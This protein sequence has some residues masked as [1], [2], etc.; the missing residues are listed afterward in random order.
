MTNSAAVEAGWLA[1]FLNILKLE[2]AK[3][4]DDSAVVGG[5]DRFIERWSRDISSQTS[6]V[7]LVR[8]L[9]RPSY[10]GMSPEQRAKWTQE[11]RKL[12][13]VDGAASAPGQETPRSKATSGK[14][15]S[16]TPAARSAGIIES[17]SETKKPQR[18]GTPGALTVDEPVDRLRGVDTKLS[19]RLK[20][21]DVATVRDLLY[22][23][24]RRHLDYSQAT[25]ITDLEPGVECTVV[26]SIW[27]S[28]EI[29]R[30]P[31]GQRKDTEALL[32]DDTGNIRVVWFG[33]RY[34][35]RTL[36][37]NL[38][39]AV[40]GK[41]SVFNGHLVFQSPEY[42]LLDTA[43]TQA[44]SGSLIHTGRMVPVYPLTEGLTGRNLRRIAWQALQEWLEGV[45]EVLPEDLLARTELIPLRR[46]IAQAHYPD[47]AEAW[48]LARQRLAF[49]ELVTLQ[50]AVLSRKRQQSQD[51]RGIK[52]QPEPQTLKGF[53]GSLPFDLTE[54]QKRCLEEIKQ[55]LERGTP[56]MN[57]LLQGEVGSGKTVVALAA[58]LMVAAAGHQAAIMV[59]TEIL[60]EQ[61]FQTVARL[62]SGL[63]SPV[64]E[65][66]QV[67]VYPESLSRPVSVGLITG[68]TKAARKRELTKM[69]S[70]GSLDILIGTQALI[71]QG[72]AM[73]R[74]ALAVAD[75]QHRFGV[76]QRSALR[77]KGEETPHTLIMSATP[78]PRT[79]SLTLYGDLEISCLDQLP[80]G[81]QE[82]WTRW[83]PPE[84]R[85][86]AHGFVRK[87]I[88]EGR[89][90][91]VICPLVE[92]S[93]SM[94]TK[95][96]TAE[97]SRLSQEVF[98]DLRLG[99]LHG[100]MTP[101]T[102]DQVMRDFRDGELDILVSTPVVEVGIDV[103]NATVMMIEG[104]DRFGL[105]QLHQFRGR[106]GRGEHKSYCLLLSDSP[107][108][109]AQERLSALERIHDGFK[110]AEADL[111]LRGP[112]DFF[113]T[114]QSGLPNLRM[115]QL[116]DR[117]LLEMARVEA[118]RII[119]SD[120][121]LSAAEHSP[122]ARQV[123]RFLEWVTDEA[124]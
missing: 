5:L 2:E 91:F 124:S 118:N 103:A 39:I 45:E 7:R 38:R 15:S 68:S 35:A 107:S 71:Q 12:L 120:P 100:R 33:Q 69:A 105:A 4:F 34:L 84:R 20:R 3:G 72:V 40:S 90:A 123:A 52:I 56:P 27:E 70:D 36:K 113:G 110:L 49:D 21:L 67:T 78:I 75:E 30:G 98:P 66:N 25:K 58:A 106:V 81:R 32:S 117:P 8:R 94:D 54:A 112:G 121:E 60:A 80:S 59:P 64:K 85:D 92:E 31:K 44:Q 48:A 115:A 47:D 93:D 9:L 111:E 28:H 122:L 10:A 6:N 102:K 104:A 24:P 29:S 11:W 42:E 63:A 50:V 43:Q 101:K 108:E 87:Q 17:P 83:L 41:P 23:F 37:P 46:A 57:R 65:D 1:P 76:M 119:D 73:P 86:A 51:T 61:H 55:D 14:K 26:G 18:P 97:Y 74:L 116:T 109:V 53:I 77:Q 13:S 79:L 88:L 99:L 82:I 22:L 96:A 19:A 114:R 62:L 89:Q 95:A 16:T